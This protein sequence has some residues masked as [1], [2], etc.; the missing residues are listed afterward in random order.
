VIVAVD[1]EGCPPEALRLVTSAFDTAKI[2]Y[3][4]SKAEGTQGSGLCGL[5]IGSKPKN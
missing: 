4:K 2:G 5:F 3:V 1:M